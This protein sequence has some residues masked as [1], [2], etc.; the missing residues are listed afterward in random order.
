MEQTPFELTSEQKGLLATLSRET[1]KPIPALL[2]EAL[3]VLQEHERLAHSHGHGT[4]NG[5]HED[6]AAQH[7]P[8]APLP[9]WQLFAEAFLDVPEEELAR[10]PTDLAAQVDHYIYGLPK[11]AE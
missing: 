5:S 8:E 11:R 2:A 6:V 4:P 3:E 1:G 9:I 7:P 10:L